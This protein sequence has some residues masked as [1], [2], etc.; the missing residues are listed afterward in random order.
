MKMEFVIKKKDFY[1]NTDPKE[2]DKVLQIPL[3]SHAHEK[4]NT[5]KGHPRGLGGPQFF[6]YPQILFFCVT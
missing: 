1:P 4:K 3:A 6:V 2:L 5:E